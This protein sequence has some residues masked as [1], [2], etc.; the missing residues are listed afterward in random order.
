MTSA[1]GIGASLR[2]LRVLDLTR[3]LAGPYCTMILGDMGQVDRATA[4]PGDFQRILKHRHHA[5]AQEIDFHDPHVL[6]VVLVPLGHAAIGHGGIFQGHDGI[7]L[8]LTNDHASG[9]LPQVTRQPVDGLV[10][11]DQGFE[12]R[13]R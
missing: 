8:S 9:M 6:T 7:Q 13:V 3:N 5:Q 10:E 11:A 1:A 12:P 4:Q 2:D